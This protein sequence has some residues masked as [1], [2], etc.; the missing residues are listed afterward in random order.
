MSLYGPLKNKKR[1]GG[2]A[3]DRPGVLAEEMRPEPAMG[4]GQSWS[5]Q[6]SLLVFFR[7]FEGSRLASRVTGC[8]C[9]TWREVTCNLVMAEIRLRAGVVVRLLV[10]FGGNTKPIAFAD[11]LN[12]G[13][14]N[15][16]W[17]WILPKAH[18]AVVTIREM[19]TTEPTQSHSPQ[20]RGGLTKIKEKH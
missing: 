2:V 6:I 14:V 17:V 20:G 12:M 7:L 3:S 11:R 9:V 8:Q 19:V 5:R 13:Y 18:L 16:M 4:M 1:T 10:C 15:W